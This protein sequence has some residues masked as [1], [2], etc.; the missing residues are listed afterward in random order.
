MRASSATR[1]KNFPVKCICSVGDSLK[2]SP[3]WLSSHWFSQVALGSDWLRG[4]AGGGGWWALSRAELDPVSQLCRYY[5]ERTLTVR[6]RERERVRIKYWQSG[7]VRQYLTVQ[8]ETTRTRQTERG[9]EWGLRSEV[10]Q[11]M[12]VLVVVIVKPAV[13]PANP[14][15]DISITIWRQV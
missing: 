15:D 4:A 3:P 7:T 14:P 9:G 8:T 6:E 11:W 1:V 12:L 13:E 2:W 10:W 5:G